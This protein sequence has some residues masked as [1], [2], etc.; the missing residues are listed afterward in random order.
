MKGRDK[1]NTKGIDVSAWQSNINFA[2]VKKEG[3]KVVIIKATEGVNFVDKRLN[4]HYLGASK[5]GLKI[6]FYHFM[7]DKTS[8]KEQARDLWSAIKDKKFHI[9]PVL[10][11]ERETMGRGK[12]EVTNRCLEFLKEFKAL[13]GYDCIVYTYT[14]FAK[15][16]LDSRLKSYPLWI[17][18][19]GVNTPGNNGIWKDWVG[20]QYTDKG[21]IKGITG[22][23]DLNEFTEEIF[24]KKSNSSS[25]NSNSSSSK[26]ELW[27]L[28]ICGPVV[29]DLQ[30]ELN[31]QFKANLKVD[32]YFG[33]NTLNKCVNVSL[34]A[35]GNITKII[36]KRLTALGYKLK[37]D[38]IFG[39]KTEKAIK[40]LQKKNKL[41]IDGIVGKNTWKVLFKK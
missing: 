30:M 34:G 35:K 23:C 19:Y 2:R 25:S 41:K 6:G 10:D 22:Y 18:H 8:P 32:G 7:S 20:F 27:Q 26:K 16:K 11:I 12:T 13:S 38:G 4:E 40:E 37:V 21:K 33:S 14:F 9:I 39:D 36:Q 15:S 24:I 17:A 5:E 29:S 28:S 31:K 3:V 1:N